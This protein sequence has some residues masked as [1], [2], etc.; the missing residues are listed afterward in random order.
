MKTRK[1]DKYV[2]QNLE[3][4]RTEVT[5]LISIGNLAKAIGQKA[6]MH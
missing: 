6:H 1:A 4:Y 2:R 5:S 3:I